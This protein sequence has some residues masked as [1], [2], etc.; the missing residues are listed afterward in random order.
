[1]CVI[2]T[3]GTQLVPEY[4]PLFAESSCNTFLYC[5][6]PNAGASLSC[7]NPLPMHTHIWEGATCTEW[8]FPPLGRRGGRQGQY[9]D[10]CVSFTVDVPP[11]IQGKLCVHGECL[12]EV[13]LC[14]E[15]AEQAF[16]KKKSVNVYKFRACCLTGAPM[17]SW[18]GFCLSCSFQ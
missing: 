8:L 14:V 18:G 10:L 9:Q 5:R 17:C 12:T 4:I 7:S 1:M 11:S 16:H 3:S 2:S 13:L 6:Q 15:P